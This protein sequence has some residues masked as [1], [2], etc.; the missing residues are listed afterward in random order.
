MFLDIVAQFAALAGFAA[1][2]AVIVNILKIFGI[3]K[4]DQAPLW[5]A[6]ANLLCILTMYFLSIFKPEFSFAGLD[7][8]M[9]EIATVATFVL[10]FVGQILV[11]KFTHYAVR[12]LPVVGKS[13]SYD[14]YM[15]SKKQSL[16]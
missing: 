8:M 3:V 4:E 16:K 9:T 12:G 2:I 15:V 5:V 7:P 10:A 14:K 6:G 1:L 13:Y 11:S